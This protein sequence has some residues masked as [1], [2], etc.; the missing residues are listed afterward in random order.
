MHPENPAVLQ[1]D[2]VNPEEDMKKEF[3]MNNILTKDIDPIPEMEV[4]NLKKIINLVH[5]LKKCGFKYHKYEKLKIH[6]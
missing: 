4:K 5:I 1:G 2:A 6:W 3:N